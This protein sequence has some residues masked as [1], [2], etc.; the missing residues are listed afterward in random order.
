MLEVVLLSGIY[1]FTC[2]NAKER[3]DIVKDKFDRGLIF[4]FRDKVSSLK[5]TILQYLPEDLLIPTIVFDGS[6][7]GGVIVKINLNDP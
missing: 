3:E 4:R 6:E 7:H 1:Q 2:V 5:N